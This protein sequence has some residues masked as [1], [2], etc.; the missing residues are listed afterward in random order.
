M[1]RA[2]L[3]LCLLIKTISS[4]N[5]QC[6]ALNNKLNQ[7]GIRIV[8][9]R[10][11]FLG[12][13]ICEDLIDDLCCPQAY[14]EDIQNATAMELTHLF[15]VYSKDLY[16]PLHHTT[17]QLNGQKNLLFDFIGNLSFLFRNDQSI[18]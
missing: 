2:L 16:Q 14:E 15:E 7:Y 11:D 5:E 9:S 12:V 17:R 10:T 1:S 8:N 18:P 3:L 6:S 13:R 4:E